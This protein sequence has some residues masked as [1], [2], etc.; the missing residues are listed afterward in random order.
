MTFAITPRFTA[1]GIPTTYYNLF[2]DAGISVEPPLDPQ[3]R[4]PIAPE[5]LLAIFPQ[6]VLEQ[7]MSAQAHVA[8]P[9]EVLEAYAA[10]RPSPLRRAQRLEKLLGTR[11]RIYY[12]FEG[13][14]PVGSH[15]LNTALPQAFYNKRE[16][17]KRLSTETGGGQ[18]GTALAYAAQRFDL[19][20]TVYMVRVSYNQKPLRKTMIE[21]FGA[22]LHA[23]PSPMTEVGRKLLALRADHPGSLGI[24]ISE[25]IE[26]A[27]HTPGTKYAIGSVLNHVLLHQTIIGQE[28][29]RQMEE[30]GEFPD[31]VVACHGG[32]SNFGGLAFP[33]VRH[34]IDGRQVQILAAEPESCPSLTKGEYRYDLGDV[35]G[36]TPLIKMHTLGSDFMPD[37]IHAG[38]LRYH[39]SSPLVSRLLSDGLIEA[40]AYPQR[41]TFD[42]ACVFARAEGLV[43]APE[44]A[45][46]I[47]GG[48]QLAREADA[49]GKPRSILIG[50]SGHGL[51]ELS[52]YEEFLQGRLG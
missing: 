38:G 33:F 30:L 34:R 28:A 16:G 11:C 21:L 1:S 18:W 5:K 19:Q 44:S 47:A 45:H 51:L 13:A 37:P 7:E 50:V 3:T 46:A 27:V 31:A 29:L 6:A 25:A 4:A 14:S 40:R 49:A 22:T 9:E 20:S 17:V 10:F 48:I 8:I 36:L 2:A 35:A 32:G 23:S 41:A 15:K 43:P 52:A 24:A 26:D 12:K 42:A 39:G